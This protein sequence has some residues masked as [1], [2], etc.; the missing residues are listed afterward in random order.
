M[1]IICFPH[2]LHACAGKLYN[3]ISDIHLA[4]VMIISTAVH[5]RTGIQNSSKS[6]KVNG[7]IM[8]DINSISVVLKH[9]WCLAGGRTT[10]MRTKSGFGLFC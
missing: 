5:V 7:H 3:I 6:W 1:H 8:C 2:L 10:K 4:A 9:N